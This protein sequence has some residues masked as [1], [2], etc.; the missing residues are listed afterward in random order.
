[1]IAHIIW[2]GG[3]S[4]ARREDH[5]ARWILYGTVGKCCNMYCKVDGVAR[6]TVM[7]DGCRELQHVGGRGVLQGGQGV[8]Q[9]MD[10][11]G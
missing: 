5:D 3:E 2:C 4:L 6:R 7:Q 10:G 1:M 8:L 11:K 9:G